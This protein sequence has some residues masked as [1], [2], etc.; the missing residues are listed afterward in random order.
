MFAAT[1][2]HT[3]RGSKYH[4]VIYLVSLLLIQNVAC[5]IC[6]LFWGSIYQRDNYTLTT[7]VGLAVFQ[8]LQS[9][10]FLLA[11]FELAWIYRFISID[12]PR[13]IEELEDDQEQDAKDRRT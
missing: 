9:M 5:F 8:S 7:I 1:L 3:L 2:V 12:T 11:H 4:T 13:K 10:S 6:D